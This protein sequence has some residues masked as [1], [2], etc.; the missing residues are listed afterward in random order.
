MGPPLTRNAS[1]SARIIPNGIRIGVFLGEGPRGQKP[2]RQIANSGHIGRPRPDLQP[3][4][5]IAAGDPGDCDE[6]N[7]NPSET[8]GVAKPKSVGLGYHRLWLGRR[9]LRETRAPAQQEERTPERI[10]RRKPA[11]RLIRGG[12]RFADENMRQ[13]RI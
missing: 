3:R 4:L 13:S 2:S 5:V 1:L 12:Y 11:P 10:V 8:T 6:G 9:W 7:L